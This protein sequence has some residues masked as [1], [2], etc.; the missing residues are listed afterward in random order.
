[1]ISRAIWNGT[2]TDLQST[3]VTGGP[4]LRG[5]ECRAYR[6][7]STTHLRD[8]LKSRISGTVRRWVEPQ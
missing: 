3:Q 8:L 5:T 1:M 7:G 4:Y 6:R 2:D